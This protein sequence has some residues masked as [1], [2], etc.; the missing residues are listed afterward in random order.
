MR[1][2]L[3]EDHV[4]FARWLSKALTDAGFTVEHASSGGDADA[5]LRGEPYALAIL[6][7]TLPEL[8]GLEI[9]KNLRTRGDATPVLILT[10][11]ASVAERVQGLNAGADDYLTKPFELTELEA[12]VKALLRRS[13]GQ[14]GPSIACGPLAFDSVNRAFTCRGA[15]LQLTPRERA[16]LEMLMMRAG[17]AISKEKLFAGLF[18]SDD[19]S[20]PDAVE[21]YVHRLR[22]KLDGS[23]VR[24]TTL[25][26][27]GYLLEA[28]GD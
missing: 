6:D 7:L 27:V 21:I 18:A 4:E 17:K 3:V 14:S 28:H 25:R 8:D 24:I 5:L 12:R 15:P 2:L 16:L 23:G 11:R 19:E 9:L 20:S 26:G 13:Q 10:A 22:R 1:I